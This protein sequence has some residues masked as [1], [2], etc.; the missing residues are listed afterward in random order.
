MLISTIDDAPGHTVT[1]EFG[2]GPTGVHACGTTVVTEL[3][4]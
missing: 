2:V 3:T 4:G 1:S